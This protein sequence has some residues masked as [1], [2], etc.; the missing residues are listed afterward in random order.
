MLEKMQGAVAHICNSRYL[1]GRG[2]RIMSLRT[3]LE[4]LAG[5]YLKNKV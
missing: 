4:K 2:K 3:A 5:A 1:G